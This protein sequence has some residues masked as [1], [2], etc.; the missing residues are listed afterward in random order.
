V[1]QWAGALFVLMVK[2]FGGDRNR[3]ASEAEGRKPIVAPLGA[4]GKWPGPPDPD[5]SAGAPGALDTRRLLRPSDPSVSVVIP[6]KDE[7][8]NI[9]WVLDRLP[10][11]V[12]EII[13]VDGQSEDRTA[14]IARAVCPE[15]KVIE[16]VN[17]GKGNAIATGLLAA[18]GDVVV[19]LDADGSMDPVEIQLYVDA[20]CAGADIV[21]GSRTIAGGGSQ[22]LSI[23]R[24]MGNRGLLLF[25]NCA[26][27]QSWSDLC[28]GYAA[29]WKDALDCLGLVELC[30]PR[31]ERQASL[32][33]HGPWYGHGFE[34]E[35]L[36]YCRAARSHL[37]VTEVVS[38]E[39]KRRSGESH[40]ATWRDGGRVMFAILREL[41]WQPH[42]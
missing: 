9:P 3:T 38:H 29:F 5:R 4:D 28:Y 34:I 35:A 25:S 37:K 40:L 30:G 15:A 12:T 6:A 36:L 1:A 42:R 20:L 2:G 17:S 24:S 33:W 14:A 39:Y 16:H 21:K 18:E 32:L 13:V 27:R 19:M 8:A 41:R 7:G 23:V 11:C 31:P 26:Y 10:E 22:D